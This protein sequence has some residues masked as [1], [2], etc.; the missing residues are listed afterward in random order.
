MKVIDYQFV[1]SVYQMKMELVKN[2]T[3]LYLKK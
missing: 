1:M 2:V 3:V